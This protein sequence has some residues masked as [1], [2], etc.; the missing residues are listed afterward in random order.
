MVTGGADFIGSKFVRRV[1]QHTDHQVTVLDNLNYAGTA[2]SLEGLP[3]NRAEL[4]AGELGDVSLV[5]DLFDQHN[6]VVHYAAES[7]ND[8]SLD[9]PARFTERTPCSPARTYSSTKASSDLVVRACIRSFGVRTTISNCSNSSVSYQHLEK[10]IPR[11]ITSVLKGLPPK[12][13]HARAKSRHW[14]HSDDYSR[15][16]L[17]ILD[18]SIIGE[19]Y[20]IGADR[21][22]SKKVV[23][24]LFLEL[25]GQPADAYERLN[26]R[27]DHDRRYSID[28]TKPRTQLGWR[29]Q[30]QGLRAGLGATIKWYRANEM[31]WAPAKVAT[32]AFCASKGQ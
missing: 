23:V 19:A 4:V 1:I 25:I 18:R 15:A 2:T 13:S 32:E 26:N 22:R 28:S 9:D 3:E 8:N 29:P 21:E 24:E 5:D 27:A 7:Q 30:Y 16:V 14:I 17:T 20:L 31:W 11:Q 10:F 12:L 6:A